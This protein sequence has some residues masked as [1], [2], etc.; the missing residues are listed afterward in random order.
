VHFEGLSLANGRAFGVS[1]NAPAGG[2]CVLMGQN[3]S[4]TLFNVRIRNCQAQGRGGAISVGAGSTL[5]V[6]NTVI[7]ENSAGL[8]GGGIYLYRSRMEADNSSIS[9]NSALNNGGGIYLDASSLS[10]VAS[11]IFANV[12]FRGIFFCVFVYS[13]TFVWLYNMRIH[14]YTLI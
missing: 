10:A 13:N 6:K 11:F 1:A 3:A 2:G 4:L 7:S 8:D 5:V 14:A 9:T 12:A